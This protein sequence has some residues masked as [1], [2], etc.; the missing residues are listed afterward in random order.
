[1]HV[2]VYIYI[3][4]YR[5]TCKS[6]F[7]HIY[8]SLRLCYFIRCICSIYLCVVLYALPPVCL[9]VCRPTIISTAYNIMVVSLIVLCLIMY[10]SITAM[11]CAS[12]MELTNCTSSDATTCEDSASDPQPNFLHSQSPALT[13]TAR[14]HP[15]RRASNSVLRRARFKR[16]R[17]RQRSNTKHVRDN[18]VIRGEESDSLAQSSVLNLLDQAFEQTK[19]LHTMQQ[20]VAPLT[21]G[22]RKQGAR[23]KARRHFAP[24]SAVSDSSSATDPSISSLPTPPAA[25]APV[26]LIVD[27]SGAAIRSYI[28]LPTQS[29]VRRNDDGHFDLIDELSKDQTYQAL[30][31][32][33]RRTRRNAGRRREARKLRQKQN[34]A[35]AEAQDNARVR[36][37]KKRRKQSKAGKQTKQTRFRQKFEELTEPCE[38]AASSLKI[39]RCRNSKC[40]LRECDDLLG[41]M[42]KARWATAERTG[43][44]KRKWL[45][46]KL[47]AMPED[48]K[49][50]VQER[51]SCCRS[52][53]NLF[54][55]LPV[56]D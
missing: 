25:S 30:T 56:F 7:K 32:R 5:R 40:K 35:P 39:Q 34:Q 47:W 18:V 38:L 2:Q 41:I 26:T 17:R 31:K 12:P 42:C 21:A 19:M 24:N 20:A 9:P 48:W 36:A 27:S 53:F 43:A 1:M 33:K 55:G 10:R 8:Q 54:H 51:K 52:C 15:R 49:L 14:N 3:Y 37:E 50:L 28:T 46:G 29:E 4:I 22:E 23:D 11:E 13:I 6:K 44:G 16:M 45:L